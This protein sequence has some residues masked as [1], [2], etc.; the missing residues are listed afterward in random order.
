[1]DLKIIREYRVKDYNVK[2]VINSNRQYDLTIIIPCYNVEKY[3]HR[4]LE[5]VLNQKT[6]Y[7]FEVICINDGSTDNT[8]Q[9]LNEYLKKDKRIKIYNQKNIGISN[10]RNNGLS[11]ANGEYI[12]F[13]D[14]DDFIEENFIEEMMNNTDGKKIDYVKCGYIKYYIYKN[15]KVYIKGKFVD[16]DYKE[17]NFLIPK[18]NGYL[19]GA[20]I[21]KEVFKDIIFPPNYWFEDMIT[22]MLILRKCNTFRYIKECLYDYSIRENSATKT[23]G[24]G[25]NIK[26]IEQLYLVEKIYEYSNKIG[27]KDDKTFYKLIINELG[28]MLYARIRGIDKKNQKYI[29]KLTCEFWKRKLYPNNYKFDFFENIYIYSFNKRRFFIWKYN[30]NIIKIL[31]KIKYI[32]IH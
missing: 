21:K 28:P 10:S 3:I 1:M 2:N 23:Q 16:A 25:K 5:S 19:W 7:S 12:S 9:I 17:L 29:F 27:L 15:K 31:K 11:L 22:R 8:K 20:V 32:I 26:N 30:S 18:I 14:S 6:K 24:K 13:V 4:C